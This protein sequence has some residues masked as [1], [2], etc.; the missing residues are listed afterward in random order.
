[1]TVLRITH[2]EAAPDN[3]EE[4]RARRNALVS[5]VRALHPGLGQVRLARLDDRR[6][7]DTWQWTSRADAEAALAD[8]PN[9]PEAKA[10]FAVTENPGGEFAVI[11]DER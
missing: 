8:A 6:W 2:F 1:M 9:L 11:E 4:M 3:V 7:V 10:A 5:A